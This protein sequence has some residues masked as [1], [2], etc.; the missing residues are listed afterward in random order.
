MRPQDP[1]T[2]NITFRLLTLPNFPL[3][4]S[5]QTE[6]NCMTSFVI[7]REKQNQFKLATDM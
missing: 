3:D 1:H 7:E 4:A 2:I 5:P 6:D